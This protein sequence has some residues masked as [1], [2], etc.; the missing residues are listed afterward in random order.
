MSEPVDLFEHI[1]TL[2]AMGAVVDQSDV[3]WMIHEITHL[4]PLARQRDEAL[5]ERDAALAE[6]VRLR[7]L[8]AGLDDV[9]VDRLCDVYNAALRASTWGETSLLSRWAAMRA[10]LDDLRERAGGGDE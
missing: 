9:E 3:D 4:S 6:V 2:R 7:G 8:L 1:K 10:V 5:A